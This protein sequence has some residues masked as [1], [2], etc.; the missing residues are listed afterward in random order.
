[1]K[2]NLKFEFKIMGNFGDLLKIFRNLSRLQEIVNFY[3]F[4]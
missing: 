3:Q 2:L 4:Y 1:M